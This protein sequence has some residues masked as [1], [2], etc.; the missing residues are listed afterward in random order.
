MM[1]CSIA[2][3]PLATAFRR[4]DTACLD[5]ARLVARRSLAAQ[6][7]ERH[8]HQSHDQSE[9]Q[10]AMAFDLLIMDGDPSRVPANHVGA[11]A[12]RHAHKSLSAGRRRS[13]GTKKFRVKLW[14]NIRP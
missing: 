6:T 11:K 2:L 1:V 10:E 5:S 4:S 12:G 8:G 7:V 14:R 3:P 9:R 13:M